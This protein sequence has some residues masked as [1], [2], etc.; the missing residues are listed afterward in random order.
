M[1]K[2]KNKV[3]FPTSKGVCKFCGETHEDFNYDSECDLCGASLK[4]VYYDFLINIEQH[5]SSFNPLYGEFECYTIRKKAEMKLLK[6][7]LDN[8]REL[9]KKKLN[10]F[11]E[12]SAKMNENR[13]F[14]GFKW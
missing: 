13:R 14:V 9:W 7:G 4:E 8:E 10:E 11:S 3:L 1:G 2:K 12:L 5:L 6:I